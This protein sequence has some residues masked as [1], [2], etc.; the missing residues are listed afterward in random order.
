MNKEIPIIYKNHLTKPNT[1]RGQS[2]VELALLLPIL[3][4]IMLG[5]LDLGRAFYY[6]SGVNNA[7]RVGAQY[8]MNPAVPD[9]QVIN[10]VVREAE[11]YVPLG[12][13][14]VA[15]SYPA[16]KATQRQF[17]VSVTYVFTFITPGANQLWGDG[18]TMNCV[19]TGRYE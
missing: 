13:A 12:S 10:A 2:V 17:S 5:A 18:I 4:M 16:G 6:Y 8:A 14:A 11:P 9:H 1:V 15:Y 3:V 19:S 7:A